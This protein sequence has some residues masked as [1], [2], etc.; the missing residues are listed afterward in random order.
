MVNL[1]LVLG[2]TPQATYMR[3]WQ[4]AEN[5]SHR[6]AGGTIRE[7]RLSEDEATVFKELGTPDVI[8]FYRQVPTR[9]RVYSWIYEASNQVIWFVEGQRVDYVEVDANTLPLSKEEQQTLK[10]KAFASGVLAGVVGGLA[11]GFILLGED[12]GLRN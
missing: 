9:E 7:E 11:T 5:M 12:I 2:C 10:Q 1:L 6:W 3:K 8:R 4:A